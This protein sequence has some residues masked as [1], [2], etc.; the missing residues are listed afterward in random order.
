MA[1]FEAVGCVR[2]CRAARL[3]YILISVT[4]ADFDTQTRNLDGLVLGLGSLVKKGN[5]G[6]YFGYVNRL[7]HHCIGVAVSIIFGVGFALLVL[8]RD[9]MRDLGV[10]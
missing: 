7:W 5:G 9:P 4:N 8:T 1:N 10:G 2:C 3:A 6:H